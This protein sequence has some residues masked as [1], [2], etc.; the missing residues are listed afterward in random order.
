MEVDP[1]NTSL[2]IDLNGLLQGLYRRKGLIIAVFC[3]VFSLVAYLAI[4]LPSVYQ[5]RAL[6]LISPQKLPASYINSTVTV[7]VEQRI[8]AIIEQILSRARLKNIVTEFDLYPGTTMEDRVGRLLQGVHTEFRRPDTIG[9]PTRDRTMIQLSFESE[10]PEKAM[11]VTARLASLFV[12]ENLQIREQ[13]AV[14][15]T[16]FINSE[17]DRLRKELEE[18]EAKVN[19]YRARNRFELPEQLNANLGTLQQLRTDLQNNTLRLSSLEER[20]AS[21]EQQA[22]QAEVV[23][24]DG[25]G[26]PQTEGAQNALLGPMQSQRIR[27]ETLLTQYS[28]KHPDVIRLKK[29]IQAAEAEALTQESKTKESPSAGVN[30]PRSPVQQMLRTQIANLNLEIN[31]LR[32]TNAELRSQIASYQ[33]RVD[34]TPV[35]SIE[36]AK[37]T[38]NYDIILRKYQDLQT[39][40]LD[41]QLSENMEKKQKGEQFQVINPANL[42]RKPIRPNRQ[43][44]LI[45]GLLAGLAGGVGLAYLLEKLDS[46]FKGSDE[47]DAYV[48]LPLLATIPGVITR[49]NVL[50]QRRANGILFLAS[51]GIVIAGVSLIRLFSSSFF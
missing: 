48:Q 46:S 8:R 50:E 27:L 31:S 33:A 49:G 3:V 17:A 19:H 37:I 35:R 43:L 12:D 41:S 34:N 16:V 5:S 51:V 10:S 24:V 18:Q 25:R 13:Q 21:L 6:I 30:L 9:A 23:L 38:R 4:S 28:E 15:T 36:V 14:G 7:T 45:I 1:V 26:V 11:Q 20:K 32:S 29:E 44:I 40:S 22:A 42:P 2:G 39:K 47:L